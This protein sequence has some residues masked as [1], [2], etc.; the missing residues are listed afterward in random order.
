MTEKSR[1]P[2]QGV[3]TDEG[4]LWATGSFS[5]QEP[6]GKDGRYALELSHSKG[7][8]PGYKCSI[9][10]LSFM[11]NLHPGVQVPPQTRSCQLAAK[12]KPSA[13][14]SRTRQQRA[15]RRVKAKEI[16]AGRSA[17]SHCGLPGDRVPSPFCPRQ[18]LSKKAFL[19]S[20]TVEAG[21]VVASEMS[22]NTTPQGLLEKVC[23]LIKGKQYIRGPFT[24]WPP[25]LSC[26]WTGHGRS[27]G[28]GPWHQLSPQLP[29]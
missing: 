1:K 7:R 27:C 26:L 14:H 25:C 22:Q 28:V 21:F 16:G 4:P 12:R 13:T 24:S 11:S 20:S 10:H 17:G 18:P 3:L 9:S 15:H 8:E 29:P 6:L 19:A 2:T 23:F 5:H